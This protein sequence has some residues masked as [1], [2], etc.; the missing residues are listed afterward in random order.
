MSRP[1]LHQCYLIEAPQSYFSH[2]CHFTRQQTSNLRLIAKLRLQMSNVTLASGCCRPVATW[3]PVT[4][5][6]FFDLC[7]VF[8]CFKLNLL[9]IFKNQEILNKYGLRDFLEKLEA[10]TTP[11]PIPAWGQQ[12]RGLPLAHRRLQP[13]HSRLAHLC[14]IQALWHPGLCRF[15]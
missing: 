13:L 3:L 15:T 8:V 6:S 12:R 7:S 9:S 2:L 10:L 5:T 1:S 14:C 11:G 4:D